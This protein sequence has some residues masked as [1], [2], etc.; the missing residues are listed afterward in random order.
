MLAGIGIAAGLVDTANLARHVRQ[1]V[2]F[3]LRQAKRRRE[4]GHY[5]LRD[6]GLVVF[7]RHNTPDMNTLDEIFSSGHYEPTE[8]VLE[9]LQS[10]PQPIEIVDLG[11]NIGLFGAFAL[12]RF[13]E[14]TILAF[15]PDP[16][17]AE[18]HERSIKANDAEGRW[19]LIRACAATADGTVA[20]SGDGYTTGRVGE[21]QR[22]LP[23]VDV[24]PFLQSVD[25]L[26]VDVEGA[27]WDLLADSRFAEVP[28][29]V[30]A[31]EYHPYLCPSADPRSLAHDLLERA[32][33]E[34]A[35]H[36]L[37]GLPGQGMVWA[38]KSR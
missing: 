28:A 7:L 32:G 14:A 3:T 33:Y 30:V 31:L 4:L 22:Q 2:R 12:G 23:A 18:L 25:L 21:G 24:F 36:E 13:P 27:E 29:S 19:R 9:A 1:P 17:N 15:E 11:A 38:W 16:A 5:R 20:F 8:A 35:D 6:S 34:T 26:K 37:R 10:V